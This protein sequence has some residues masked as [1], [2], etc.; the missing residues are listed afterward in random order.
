[1]HTKTNAHLETAAN[2][3]ENEMSTK[4]ETLDQIYVG[5]KPIGSG[6]SIVKTDMSIVVF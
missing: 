6:W 2:E 4:I 3:Q 1:M 5:N